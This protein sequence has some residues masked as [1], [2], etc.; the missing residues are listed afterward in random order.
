VVVVAVL[1]VVEGEN[2]AVVEGDD[3]AVVGG[4]LAALGV[5]VVLVWV[6]CFALL[7]SGPA[8][9]LRAGF[10]RYSRRGGG[11]GV[12]H[13]GVGLEHGCGRREDAGPRDAVVV[14]VKELLRDGFCQFGF[15]GF[16]A[17]Q[18]RDVSDA[19]H[20][21]EFAQVLEQESPPCDAEHPTHRFGDLVGD[22][23]EVL[24]GGGG[25]EFAEVFAGVSDDDV[26]GGADVAGLRC[27]RRRHG[28]ESGRRV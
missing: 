25:E 12:V 4:S 28:G 9:V 2:G 20:E 26:G 10:F 7:G 1:S 11:G 18:G 19:V 22:A 27:G 3:G 8:G 23:L 6:Q 13:S 5:G 16:A 14:Q 15:V 17:G 21:G 24:V